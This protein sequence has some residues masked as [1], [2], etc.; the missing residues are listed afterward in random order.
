MDYFLEHPLSFPPFNPPI[1]TEPTCCA[2]VKDNLVSSA[3]HLYLYGYSQSQFSQGVSTCECFVGKVD[4]SFCSVA[5]TKGAVKKTA[6]A[7]AKEVAPSYA[8]SWSS[9]HRS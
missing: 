5:A 8:S 4:L 6:K 3:I 1:A 9:C 7:K 2:V